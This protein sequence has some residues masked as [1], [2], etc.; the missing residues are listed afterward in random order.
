MLS[1]SCPALVK[2]CSAL[3]SFVS[4]SAVLSLPA[5]A[6]MEAKSWMT[7][8]RFTTNIQSQQPLR[9]TPSTSLIAEVSVRSIADELTTASDTFSSLSTA[10]RAA[11]LQKLNEHIKRH[12]YTYVSNRL[13]IY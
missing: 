1:N 4:V 9:V 13:K 3:F 8:D 12:L 7:N 11:L 2:T 5:A 10:I 6:Q